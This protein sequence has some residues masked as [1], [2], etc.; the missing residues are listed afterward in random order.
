MT[1]YL[2]CPVLRDLSL[3]MGQP[4]F[5]HWTVKQLELK[6][7][8]L[9][10]PIQ[11]WQ[12]KLECVIMGVAGWPHHLFRWRFRAHES[13]ITFS[14]HYIMHGH[15][16]FH[17][18]VDS[19]KDK[20]RVSIQRYYSKRLHNCYTVLL[21]HCCAKVCLV[22]KTLNDLS[23]VAFVA[24]IYNKGGIVWD[25][26]FVIGKTRFGEMNGL[27]ENRFR[28]A[29]TYHIKL[30]F[31]FWKDRPSFLNQKLDIKNINSLAYW[32]CRPGR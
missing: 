22:Y 2:N 5:S 14:Q 32:S 25:Q 29:A 11:H 30:I 8:A 13:L 23:G 15:H 6:P 9:Q 21:Q 24:G 28:W 1:C 12:K 17:P 4:M 7:T 16:F 19:S 18:L 20:Q 27:W 31:W 3:W 26:G 10:C